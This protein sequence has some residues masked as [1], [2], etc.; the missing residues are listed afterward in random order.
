MAHIQLGSSP[1][2]RKQGD[3][4]LDLAARKVVRPIAPRSYSLWMAL[5]LGVVLGLAYG[6]SNQFINSIFSPPSASIPF[7]HHPFG[8]IGNCIASIL[9]MMLICF[10]CAWPKDWT[11][12]ALFGSLALFLVM[13]IRA[14]AT[15]TP[16]LDVFL[17]SFLSFGLLGTFLEIVLCIPVMAILRWTID[18][19]AELFDRPVYSWQRLRIPVG[20]TVAATALGLLSLY[21]SSTLD[22]MANTASLINR[23]R[24]A[25]RSENLPAPLRE[26]NGVHDFLKYA[27]PDFTVELG[28]TTP[29]AD[30]IPPLLQ[31]YAIVIIARFQ[32]GWTVTCLYIDPSDE[33]LCKSSSP[34]NTPRITDFWAAAVQPVS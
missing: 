22:A 2:E 23:G 16:V 15:G 11:K 12:G 9:G 19:Q 27:G 24:A 30:K 3:F 26:E 34:P 7:A 1:E 25:A 29:F 8:I 13:E 31:P 20:I 6:L 17:V 14:V 5:L 33:P 28:E 18:V 21:P 4:F 32:G 10:A